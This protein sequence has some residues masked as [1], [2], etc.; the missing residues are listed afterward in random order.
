MNSNRKKFLLFQL[1][2]LFL[3]SR[4]F[5]G[6][7]FIWSIDLIKSYLKRDEYETKRNYSNEKLKLFKRSKHWV[8]I[9]VIFILWYILLSTILILNNKEAKVQELKGT[10]K[11]AADIINYGDRV[12][13]I[14]I[15]MY[16]V[17]NSSMLRKIIV[18]TIKNLHRIFS[19]NI[20]CRM[21][22]LL[23]ILFLTEL[24]DLTIH[25]FY[26]IIFSINRS[27]DADAYSKIIYFSCRLLFTI[28]SKSISFAICF[29][30][31][32]S[33]QMIAEYISSILNEYERPST[34]YKDSGN[35]SLLNLNEKDYLIQIS[36]KIT[37]QINNLYVINNYFKF[38][39]SVMIL[40]TVVFLIN[41]LFSSTNISS[42]V[43]PFP[44]YISGISS[45]FLILI[46]LCNAP[47]QII[48]QVSEKNL[49]I[50][51]IQ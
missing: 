25:S 2:V 31:C 40:R 5:G 42:P 4:F 18:I 14:L 3:V 21:Q 50:M 47:D 19:E 22:Y 7:P 1:N 24:S 46:V 15:A 27:N 12:S 23:F 36:K 43:I 49:F 44:M 16:F 9:S 48:C 38:P 13:N 26:S 6:F 29:T 10:E 20:N 33:L 41:Y 45:S 39:I 11:V 34:F 37:T 51:L 17:K 35:S 28:P 32:S 8:F 30:F